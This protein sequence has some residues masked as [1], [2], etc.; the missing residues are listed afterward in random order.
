MT[1]GLSVSQKS[2]ERTFQL[3]APAQSLGGRSLREEQTGGQ[4]GRR[5]VVWEGGEQ[6][7]DQVQWEA[8]AGFEAET[9]RDVTDF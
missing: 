6:G 5:Q 8:V 1:G 3:E 4:C 7:A 9:W 2:Q